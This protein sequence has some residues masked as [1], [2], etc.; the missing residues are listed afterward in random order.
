[1]KTED[2]INVLTYHD[3]DGM[4]A[5]TSY[6]IGGDVPEDIWRKLIAIMNDAEGSVP[7]GSSIQSLVW[8]KVRT[9]LGF[10]RI[11]FTTPTNRLFLVTKPNGSRWIW[12]PDCEGNLK[13]FRLEGEPALHCYYK[14]TKHQDKRFE[15]WAKV[16][17]DIN[18]GNL[19]K[20][21]PLR[22]VMTDFDPFD[23]YTKKWFMAC[24]REF[25]RNTDYIEALNPEGCL[26]YVPRR[27]YI[28]E[29]IDGIVKLFI[30]VKTYGVDII[31]E[32]NSD[33]QLNNQ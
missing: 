22:D 18:G 25:C 8:L 6:E 10:A 24:L 4:M 30:Y 29:N 2:E 11:F 27:K 9:R 12:R 26:G 13:F 15:D 16:F 19:N 20:Y 32:I 17:F 5:E 3:L 31:K 1:M 33:K 28:I 7:V 23:R 21:L 14:I